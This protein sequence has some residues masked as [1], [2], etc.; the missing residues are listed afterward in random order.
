MF[1]HHRVITAT[2]LS[3]VA[4]ITVGCSGGERPADPPQPR[5]VRP[6]VSAPAPAVP[7]TG[8]VIPAAEERVVSSRFEDGEAAYHARNYTEATEIFSRYTGLHP[9]NAWGH[10]MLGLSSW[11]AGDRATAE[12]AFGEALRLDPSHLKSL[13]NLS[14]VLLDDNRPAEAV[15]ALE[16]ARELAG[17]SAEVH[18]LLGRAYGVQGRTSEAIQAY[19]RAIALDPQD[20]WA[21]NNLGLILLEERRAADA[22]PLLARAVELRTGEAVFQN[23]LG[24]ALEHT[25]HFAAAA[26]AYGLALEADPG[27]EKARRNLARVE[28][29][30]SPAQPPFD[31]EAAAQRA[32]DVIATSHDKPAT[33]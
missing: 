25:G 18:R 2:A 28:G 1:Q 15:D 7:T 4:A 3:L 13:T 16:R 27:N 26:D 33:P 24:M 5:T 12:G 10:F 30:K 23:N 20:A 14:R 19:E 22:L 17:S 32:L 21:L 31:R 6:P 9:R 8:A 11:K 29:V